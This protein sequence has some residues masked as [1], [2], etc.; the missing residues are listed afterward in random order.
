VGGRDSPGADVGVA[1]DPARANA[2]LETF[3]NPSS[4]RVPAQDAKERPLAAQFE[5]P[6][7]L[8][9]E[10]CLLIYILAFPY[11]CPAA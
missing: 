2:A 8:A 5:D 3:L 6:K 10:T 4:R 9:V 11:G 1:R 7:L